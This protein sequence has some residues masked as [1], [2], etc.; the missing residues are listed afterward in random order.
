MVRWKSEKA[1]ACGGTPLATTTAPPLDDS[2]A[3]LIIEEQRGRPSYRTLLQIAHQGW[4]A[5]AA[6]RDADPGAPRP[7]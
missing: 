1:S 5:R 2:A 3:Q 6:S 7:A 4:K